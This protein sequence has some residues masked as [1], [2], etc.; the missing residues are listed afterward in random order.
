MRV[1]DKF[2]IALFIAISFHVLMV[3]IIGFDFELPSPKP[4]TLE[5]TLVQHTTKAPAEADFI[6]QANQQASGT[7]LRKQKLT[8]T[9]NARFLSDTIQEISP[10]VQPQLASAEPIDEPSLLATRNQ[11]AV[12]EIINES[13]NEPKTLEEKFR[14]ETQIPSHISND[15]A[16]LEALLDQQRQAYAK[17][18]RI[19]RLTSVSAKAAVDAQ[20]LDDWRRRIERIGNIHY[21]EEAKRNHLYGELRLAVIIQPNGYVDDIEVLHSSGIRVLDDAAMRIVRLAEPFQVFPSELKKEVD[22]LEIIRTWRFVPGNQLQ[23]Q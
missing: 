20:Y 21:P 22:K 10:P 4:K 23:S 19:R 1:T 13:E 16:T 7:E 8:T 6:A 18:P 15:I 11:E 9:E 3:M 5:V 17:R 2:S 14:G 12:F